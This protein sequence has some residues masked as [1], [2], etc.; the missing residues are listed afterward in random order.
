MTEAS[1]D[2]YVGTGHLLLSL[3]YPSYGCEKR[4]DDDSSDTVFL[5]RY[6]HEFPAGCVWCD[7]P[8]TSK[9]SSDL[10]HSPNTHV[11]TPSGVAS[12]HLCGT[13]PSFER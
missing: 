11:S 1:P 3:G 4:L 12:S 9:P 8:G 2:V 5:A 13:Q 7:T 6:T 10:L